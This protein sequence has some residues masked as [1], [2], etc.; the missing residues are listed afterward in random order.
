MKEIA[1]G[2]LPFELDCRKLLVEKNVE[3]YLYMAAKMAREKKEALRLKELTETQNRGCF[4]L[5]YDFFVV[6]TNSVD[7][8][9]I[10]QLYFF[11]ISDSDFRLFTW[12]RSSINYKIFK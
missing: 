11:S 10:W 8:S 3:N 4:K 5:C 7:S 6:K 12:I 9:I 1:F 2:N